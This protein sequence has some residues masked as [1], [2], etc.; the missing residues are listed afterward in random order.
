MVTTKVPVSETIHSQ[1]LD[2]WMDYRCYWIEGL[3][4]KV[5]NLQ[6]F[7]KHPIDIP[8]QYSLEDEQ[9]S[10]KNLV[11]VQ[12]LNTHEGGVVFG[13]CSPVAI[14]VDIHI[15][16]NLQGS[17]FSLHGVVTHC[18]QLDD[19]HCDVGVQFKEDNEHCLLYTSPSPR[20]A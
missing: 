7:I 17:E 9:P 18:I 19:E 4:T 2:A 3:E 6:G 5:C 8:F 12:V 16:V 14:G 20:D 1:Q 15:R 10:K 13:T 11:N